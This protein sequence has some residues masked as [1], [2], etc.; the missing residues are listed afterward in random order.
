MIKRVFLL[1]AAVLLT[2]ALAQQDPHHPDNEA[3]QAPAAPMLAQNM[4]EQPQMPMMGQGQMDMMQMMQGMMGQMGMMGPMMSQM[5]EQMPMDMMGGGLMMLSGPAFE[6]AFLSMMI[7]HHQSAVEMSQ[8]I[9]ETTTDEDVRAL[10]EAIISA[11]EKEI[12]EMQALLT[13]LGG[14]NLAAQMMMSQSMD[15]MM[16]AMSGTGQATNADKAFL[17]AMVEHHLSA[18]DMGSQALRK[19]TDPRILELA[20]TIVSD[21]ANEVLQLRQKLATLNE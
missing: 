7:P 15:S 10:A 13:E 14:T 19:A 20:A 6:Q 9:L 21:Q 4:T 8:T 1:V 12:E 18:I 17:E 16:A 11:Q 3:T 5:M 2:A